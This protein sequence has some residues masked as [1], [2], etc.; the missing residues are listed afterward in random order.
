MALFDLRK[1]DLER[2]NLTAGNVRWQQLFRVLGRQKQATQIAA[3]V[4]TMRWNWAAIAEIKVQRRADAVV[5]KMLDRGLASGNAAVVL[6]PFFRREF[7]D[8]NGA[9]LGFSS[10]TDRVRD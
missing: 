10:P 4:S 2:E 7:I 1:L 8:T 3:A 6:K 9:G 5:I